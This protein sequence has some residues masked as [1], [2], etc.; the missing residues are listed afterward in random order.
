MKNEDRLTSEFKKTTWSTFN[1]NIDH[2]ELVDDFTDYQLRKVM[3]EPVGPYVVSAYTTVMHLVQGLVLAALFYVITIQPQITPII[4]FKVA[5]SLGIVIT[6][7]HHVLTNT[8]YGSAIR[9]SIYN[10]LFPIGW[11]LFQVILALT[12]NYPLYI[13]TLLIIPIFLITIIHLLDHVKKHENPQAFKTWKA[14][15][16]GFNPQ[17]VQDLYD[18]FTSFEKDQMT[19]IIYFTI[20]LAVLVAFNYFFTLNLEIET[21]VSL[22]IIGIFIVLSNYFDLN[23]FFNHSEKLKKYGYRW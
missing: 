20:V 15:Y 10:T 13:F 16:K 3:H 4:I 8:Q 19:K 17:F 5:I 7:W 22:T 12:F 21:Y 9:A 18:E 11:G 14:H 1:N 6:I 23:H 2:D